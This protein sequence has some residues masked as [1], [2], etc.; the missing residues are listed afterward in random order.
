MQGVTPKR[1]NP[2][3]VR[4]WQRL[5]ALRKG[6][7]LPKKN[8]SKP[9]AFDEGKRLFS[10]RLGK[11]VVPNAGWITQGVER[12]LLELDLLPIGER[13]KRMEGLAK[14]LRNARYRSGRLRFLSVVPPGE[15]T[16]QIKRVDG[17]I[18]EAKNTLENMK[19]V[20]EH[21]GIRLKKAGIR[22]EDIPHPSSAAIVRST[23]GKDESIIFSAPPIAKLYERLDKRKGSK[24]QLTGWAFGEEYE[25]E[26][27]KA[28][29]FGIGVIQHARLEGAGVKTSEIK[30]I[31]PIRI[32]RKSTGVQGKAG[33]GREIPGLKNTQYYILYHLLKRAIENGS[34]QVH[35]IS[36][37]KAASNAFVWK[38]WREGDEN[39]MLAK[40]PFALIYKE[41]GGLSKETCP[42]HSYRFHYVFHRRKPLSERI[43]C[44]LKKLIQR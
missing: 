31:Q 21:W 5:D 10:K 23:Y 15:E 24:I 25:R 28:G 35:L 17:R 18:R 9:G 27:K 13:I 36:P 26:L 6:E 1:Q 42:D 38:G 12:E 33:T 34:E 40:H 30:V 11:E 19:R 8:W 39:D 22:E 20:F 2:H 3:L 32:Y 14:A 44:G 43:S 4:K 37:E 41:I 7:R 16:Q 29:A